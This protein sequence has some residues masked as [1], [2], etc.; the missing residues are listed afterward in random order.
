LV[1]RWLV[2][3]KAVRTSVCRVGLLLL[4]KLHTTARAGPSWLDNANEYTWKN[5]AYTIDD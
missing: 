4:L 1:V 2:C 3:G 5:G